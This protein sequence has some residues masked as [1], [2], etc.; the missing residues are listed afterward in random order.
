MPAHAGA[1]I[2]AYPELSCTG[3]PTGREFCPGNDATYKFLEG[4]LTEVLQVFPG[5]Y[6]HVGGDEASRADWKTCPKCQARMKREGLNN[7]SE[8]QSYF[9]RRI[10]KFLN[11]HGRTLVGWDEIL[12]GGVAPNAVVMSWHGTGGA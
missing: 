12:E 3:T 7:E 11:S 8:L 2:A 6:I 4:V 9:I 1:A 10:E 5:K